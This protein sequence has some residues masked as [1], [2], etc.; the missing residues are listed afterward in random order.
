MSAYVQS[1]NQSINWVSRLGQQLAVVLY[2]AT[3]VL[4]SLRST[5]RAVRPSRKQE[6]G[7]HTESGKKP[8]TL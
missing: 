4:R 7:R 2:I 5:M 8:A 3:L 6:N 1:L